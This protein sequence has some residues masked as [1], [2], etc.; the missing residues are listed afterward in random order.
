[1]SKLF[2]N[3]SADLLKSGYGIEFH[4]NGKSMYPTIRDGEMITVEPIAAPEIKP[5]DIILYRN[6]TGVVAHRVV[7]L[8]QSSH[9]HLLLR[10]DA[11]NTFDAPIM[12]Y[13]ILGKVISTKRSGRKIA[14]NKRRPNLV[15][16]LRVRLRQM[17]QSVVVLFL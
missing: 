17:I 11:S 12:P 3:I 9:G 5:G 10:G 16:F 1:M 4:A 6:Q 15:H 13:Q 8:E 7:Y 14:L 2:L